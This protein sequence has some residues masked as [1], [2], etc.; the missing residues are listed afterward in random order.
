MLCAILWLQWCHEPKQ[1]CLSSSVNTTYQ[2]SLKADGRTKGKG[3]NDALY[4]SGPRD[5]T[6]GTGY[7]CSWQELPAG[8]QLDSPISSQLQSG[9]TVT[10]EGGLA[11]SRPPTCHVCTHMINNSNNHPKCL[12]YRLAVVE[13]TDQ[14][15]S[16]GKEPWNLLDDC[17]G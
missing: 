7:L 4:F 16:R 5:R 15:H 12:F 9:P 3:R 11:G 10:R 6:R 2:E 8:E 17:L 14:L 13:C 1:D